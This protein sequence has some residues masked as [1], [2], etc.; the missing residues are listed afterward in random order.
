LKGLVQFLGWKCRRL[1]ALPCLAISFI[2]PLLI[3]ARHR[4]PAGTYVK[5]FVHGDFART[6]PSLGTIL[7]C[8]ADIL[9]LDVM[10]VQLDWPPSLE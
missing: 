5:E 10:D 4:L 6:V 7:G 1:L 3:A 2:H 8:K 9:S